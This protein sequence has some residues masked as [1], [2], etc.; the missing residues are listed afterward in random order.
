MSVSHGPYEG[1]KYQTF[2]GDCQQLLCYN[3]SIKFIIHNINVS[4]DWNYTHSKLN[5]IHMGNGMENALTWTSK[6]VGSFDFHKVFEGICTTPKVKSLSNN[7][8]NNICEKES[9]L[10]FAL[11]SLIINKKLA[12]I[13]NGIK[14]LYTAV[15]RILIFACF[16][17][18]NK[19]HLG[20]LWGKWI[21]SFMR[22]SKRNQ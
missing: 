4:L 20:S 12:P 18:N 6:H 17:P 16:V 2:D 5:D 14:L 13:N 15:N 7:V 1:Y 9:L 19:R 3:S 8:E 11:I 22:R 21:V 10:P